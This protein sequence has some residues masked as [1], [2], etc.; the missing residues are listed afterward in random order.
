MLLFMEPSITDTQEAPSTLF[1]WRDSFLHP[2]FV[3]EVLLTVTMLVLSVYIC[4]EVM[5]YAHTRPGVVLDDPI[6]RMVG[7]VNLRWPVFLI[8]WSSLVLGVC[9]LAKTPVRLL[10]WLQAAA[11]LTLFRAMALYLVPLAAPS[12]IIPLADPIA[13]LRTNT[14]TI[15][16]SD[17]FFSGHTAMMFLLFLVTTSTRLRCFFFAGF[18]FVGVSVV[19]QHVHY[20]GDV[21]AAPFFAYGSWRLVLLM[22]KT[23]RRL[24]HID[25]GNKQDGLFSTIK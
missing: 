3:G 14:G 18:V 20:S 13:T 16:T 5:L 24:L 9:S 2:R 23:L 4:R 21:F 6:Q 10:M 22:H 8:L 17:L 15:I 12:T 7:P 25:E 11:L 19:V 1:L